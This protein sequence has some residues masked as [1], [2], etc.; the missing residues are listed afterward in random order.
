[1]SCECFFANSV[2]SMSFLRVDKDL[3][4]VMYYFGSKLTKIFEILSEINSIRV[5]CIIFFKP[6]YSPLKYLEL[7]FEA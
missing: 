2:Q 6:K 1:M 3:C 7:N 4:P 5:E